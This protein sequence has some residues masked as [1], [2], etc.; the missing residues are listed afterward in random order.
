APYPA[1]DEGT[2]PIYPTADAVGTNFVCFGSQMEKDSDKLHAAMDVLNRASSKD[3]YILR[4]YGIEGETFD[5][6]DGVPQLKPEFGNPD[7]QAKAGIAWM[8]VLHS[9]TDFD[10][11]MA[12]WPKDVQEQVK[13]QFLPADGAYGK[14]NI[15]MKQIIPPGPVTSSSG[16]DLTV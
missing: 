12:L 4:N 11:Q 6:V 1:L 3:M 7:A 15:T 13:T 5:Y 14:N 16:E 10:V 9:F 8:G 2:K